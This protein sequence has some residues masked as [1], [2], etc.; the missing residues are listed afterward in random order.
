M[1][2]VIVT[3]QALCARAVG[4]R[5]CA[6]LACAL[7]AVSGCST[8]A[9]SEATSA[10]AVSVRTRPADMRTLAELGLVNGPVNFWLPGDKAI[11]SRIDQPNVVTLT[12]S[13]DN[14][15]ALATHLSSQLGTMGWT[16]DAD[17]NGSLLFHTDGWRGAFT[18]PTPGEKAT[19]AAL[20]LRKE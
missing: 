6:A 17:R 10:P 16:I 14:G 2:Q 19:V 12:Y 1:S 20:T 13:A 7:L 18:T 9:S 8:G 11:R 5:A 3:C 4:A 15:A